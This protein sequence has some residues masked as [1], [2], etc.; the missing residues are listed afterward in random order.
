M[1]ISHSTLAF[2]FGMLGNVISFLVFLAPITTFYR[3]FKKKSTEGFQ[4]L[5]YLVAL[6]SSMLW[7]YYALLK[8][9]AMLLLTINSFGC[10]IEIIYI[11]L[12]ITYATGDARNL[13]L[14]LFFAMNVGAFALILL[15][16]HFAVHGSLRVQVLGWI[17]V[18][19]SISVF[20]APL[21]I[22]AQ[23]VRTKSVEFMPF[24]LSFTLTLSAIMWFGYGLFLKDI[25]IALPNVLGFALGLL[26]MLLYAI[27]RNGNKKVDKILEK[28][29]PLE[30]LKSVVIETG[31]VFLVEEKQQG[32]KSKESSEEK[33]K[34]DEPN[35]DCAV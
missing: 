4:S 30:P 19:L 12:Y 27:Y 20:A 3:I 2:A 13:T 32:K 1:A 22:V 33:E 11:I 26:Q 35:N 7:L 17:C 23:V 15:V 21:S 25:C 18:S 10:V 16:T 8:K 5:P 29:A 9:D 34:S 28:K 14:K 24:N 31:E 6:F